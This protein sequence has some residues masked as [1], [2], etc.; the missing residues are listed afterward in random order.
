MRKVL[1]IYPDPPGFSGQRAASEQIVRLLANEGFQF[2]EVKI[3]GFPRVRAGLGEK[4]GYFGKL[5]G[6]Y[7]R[8]A[9][10]SA[11][12][13]DIVYV[14]LTQSKASLFREWFLISLLRFLGCNAPLVMSLH[15]S[16]FMDWQPHERIA[17]LFAKLLNQARVVTV[18]GP[19]Q[20]AHLVKLGVEPHRVRVVPNTCEVTPLE[21]PAV[22]EKHARG[23]PR[24][25]LHLSTLM[26]P[27][28]YAEFVEAAPM[29]SSTPVRAVV[30]GLL[31]SSAYDKRFSSL[32]DAENWLAAQAGEGKLEWVRGAKGTA[33][34]RLFED[35]QIFVF[36]SWYPVEAQ[37]LV[38]LEAMAAGCAVVTTRIGEIEYMLDAES[39]LFVDDTQ[40]A[41]LAEAMSKLAQDDELRTRLS[42]NGR[43]RYLDQFSPRAYREHW[44]EILGRKA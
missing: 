40:P 20:Q 3:P 34:Q 17:R 15:G 24:E 23:G 7:P 11:R 43:Q 32:E 18:L 21:E 10:E 29:V 2:Q 14:N 39:A 27:K 30:C 19:R 16:V 26:E 37:P 44:I 28:G 36:P 5:L 6:L 1:F 38:L 35:A 9:V 33:K 4:L 13:V 42:M 22:R 8:V 41:T 12:A 31:T 25:V